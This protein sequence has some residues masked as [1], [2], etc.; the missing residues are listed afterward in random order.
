M[1]LIGI[2]GPMGSGKTLLATALAV[3][4]SRTYGRVVLA[5]YRIDA[6]KAGI[7]GRYE[8]L[9][10]DQLLSYAKRF[11]DVIVGKVLVLDE[12]YAFGLDSR[13]SSSAL[14]RIS[15]YV[16]FQTRKL[17]TDLIYTAQLFGAV[18]LRI[19]QLTDLLIAARRAPDGFSYTFWRRDTDA[20]RTY[21][22]LESAARRIYALYNT[23]EIINPVYQVKE[24]ERREQE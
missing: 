9:T 5:N 20:V 3:D 8:Y 16:V 23:K 22:M 17:D 10:P 13:M 11:S 1:T 4:I 21:F 15:S 2:T 24:R 12:I 7:P 6:E 14:N 18:D 19:R